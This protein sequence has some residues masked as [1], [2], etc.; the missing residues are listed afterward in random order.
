MNRIVAAVRRRCG[1]HGTRAAHDRAGRLVRDGPSVVAGRTPDRL[2]SLG[3]NRTSRAGTSGRSGSTQAEG[4]CGRRSAGPRRPVGDGAMVRRSPDGA[5]IFDWSPRPILHPVPDQ[6]ERPSHRSST[7]DGPGGPGP[8]LDA[9]GFRSRAGSGSRP[10]R[11][12]ASRPRRL[13]KGRTPG[14]R[15]RGSRCR[16]LGCGERIRTSDL[17]VMSPTSCRCSTPRPITLGPEADSVKPERGREAGGG[18]STDCDVV[19]RRRST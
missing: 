11:R 5:S 10:D 12:S 1:R 8:G 15:A 14:G 6:G 13:R 7:L 17:R 16:R 2:R 9:V 4:R 18:L 19:V 3:H